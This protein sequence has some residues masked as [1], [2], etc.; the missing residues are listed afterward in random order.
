MAADPRSIA[1][2]AD[3][4]AGLEALRSAAG[5]PPLRR[6][7]VR[8]KTLG[9]RISRSTLSRIFSGK[10]VPDSGTLITILRALGV[11]EANRRSWLVALDRV[12]SSDSTHAVSGNPPAATIKPPAA[13]AA[14]AGWQGDVALIVHALADVL[15]PLARQTA[16]SHRTKSMR[17]GDTDDQNV[18]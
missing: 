4:V 10:T 11:Q 1:T 12:K 16:A 7:E 17:G 13:R 6:I 18:E 2:P 15:E 5:Y 14:G 9:N 8:T 3:L